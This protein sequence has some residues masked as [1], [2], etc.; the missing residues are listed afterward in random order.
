MTP[1]P[2]VARL[3]AESRAAQGL[4]PTIEDP[5]ALAHIAR[6][7]ADCAERRREAS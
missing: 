6:V 4:P 7:L 1:R 3:V 2:D 5:A